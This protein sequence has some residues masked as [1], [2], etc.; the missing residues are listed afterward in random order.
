MAR[1]KTVSVETGT[2][3]V[4]S[5]GTATVIL[6]S[7]FLAVPSVYVSAGTNESGQSDPG[8]STTAS[9]NANVYVTAVSNSAGAWT[10]TVNTEGFDDIPGAPGDR[11]HIG[12][13]PIYQN[14]KLIYRAVG[15]VS[16]V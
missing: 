6:E 8:D 14:I 16:A 12:K 9:W 4:S 1:F 10:F 3:T 5:N 15:P 2:V 7:E 11:S 13:E